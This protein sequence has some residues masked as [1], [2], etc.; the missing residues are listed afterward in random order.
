MTYNPTKRRWY[1][2]DKAKP[3]ANVSD[4]K[5]KNKQDDKVEGGSE[6]DEAMIVATG[7][8]GEVLKG[9]RDTLKKA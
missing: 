4:D 7:K 3:A 9:I 2:D 6:V 1:C 5:P 8:I